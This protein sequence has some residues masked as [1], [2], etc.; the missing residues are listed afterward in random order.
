MG[1][2]GTTTNF[3]LLFK[4]DNVER[5]RITNAGLW[6][7]GTSSPN[8][9]VHINSASGQSPLGVQ[10]NGSTKF[11]VNSSGGVSV[12]SSTSAPTNGLFVAGNVGIGIA[13]PKNKLH[14][15]NGSA[16]A[17]TGFPFASLIVE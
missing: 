11:L 3:S 4:S 10:V 9:K 8:S 5:G 17:V 14:I 16:G 6:G 12:G 2:L 1:T 13:T 7:I 15:F